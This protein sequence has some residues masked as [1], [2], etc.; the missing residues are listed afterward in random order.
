M[1]DGSSS[2]SIC[3]PVLPNLL[4]FVSGRASS[5]KIAF[6]YQQRA[7]SSASLRSTSPRPAGNGKSQSPVGRRRPALPARA[8]AD[9]PPGQRA[10]YN[11]PQEATAPRAPGDASAARAVASAASRT[12]SARTPPAVARGPDGAV[13]FLADLRRHVLRGSC[14]YFLRDPDA[15]PAPAAGDA[16]PRESFQSL[17]A[18]VTCGEIAAPVPARPPRPRV[19]A[20]IEAGAS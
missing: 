7:P 13:L 10:V 1:D 15:A 20:P 5:N 8:P 4:A 3:D 19:A 18:R 17:V 12:L 6:F 11:R 9:A 16:P 2:D 14:I